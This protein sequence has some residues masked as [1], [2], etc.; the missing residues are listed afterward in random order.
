MA[1]DPAKASVKSASI[2]LDLSNLSIEQRKQLQVKLKDLAKGIAPDARLG[3]LLAAESG[4]VSHNDTDGW[5]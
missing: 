5:F 3:S 2:Q 1:R 4:H